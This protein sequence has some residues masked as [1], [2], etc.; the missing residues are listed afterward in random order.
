MVGVEKDIDD[1]AKEYMDNEYLSNN[2]FTLCNVLLELNNSDAKEIFGY[3]DYIKLRSSLT[4]F[5]LVT[6]NIIIKKVLDKFYN[7]ELDNTTLSK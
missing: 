3:I 5:Y 7:G 1:E 4:L 6:N 2:Y